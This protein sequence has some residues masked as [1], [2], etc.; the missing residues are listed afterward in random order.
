MTHSKK[1]VTAIVALALSSSAFAVTS[2]PTDSFTAG[3]SAPTPTVSVFV[4]SDGDTEMTTTYTIGQANSDDYTYPTEAFAIKFAYD[5]AT[6]LGLSIASS[7]LVDGWSLAYKYTSYT[8]GAANINVGTNLS[9]GAIGGMVA[10]NGNSSTGTYASAVAASTSA[11]AKVDADFTN[12]TMFKIGAKS[13]NTTTST[14]SATVTITA[15]VN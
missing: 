6:N 15:T 11:F 7:T 14:L 5:N 4:M 9:L 8:A 3:A 13:T 12:A 2:S 10:A 1:F